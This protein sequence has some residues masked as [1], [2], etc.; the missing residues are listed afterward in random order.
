MSFQVFHVPVVVPG[1]EY[2][3]TKEILPP[4]ELSK[5]RVDLYLQGLQEFEGTQAFEVA[6]KA[7]KTIVPYE[8]FMQQ[9]SK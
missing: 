8:T 6:T 5:R 4:G 9:A 3:E 1:P 7:S 2:T